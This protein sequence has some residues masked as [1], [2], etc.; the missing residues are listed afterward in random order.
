MWDPISASPCTLLFA[1]N[2]TKSIDT[3]T[4]NTSLLDIQDN[5]IH[6]LHSLNVHYFMR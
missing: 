3:F 2:K 1:K 6:F 5:N 4:F